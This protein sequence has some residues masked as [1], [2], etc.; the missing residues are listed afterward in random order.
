MV[1]PLLFHI[2]INNHQ[3][4][5]HPPIVDKQVKR[6]TLR[7]ARVCVWQGCDRLSQDMHLPSP[8]SS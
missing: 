2:S 8:Q 3:I 7:L 6:L 4:L 1:L 5:G